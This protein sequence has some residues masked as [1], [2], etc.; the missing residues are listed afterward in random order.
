MSTRKKQHGFS[1]IELMVVI[2]VVGSL[3]G[4]AMPSLRATIDRNVVSSETIRLVRSINLARSQ[5]VNKQQVVTLERKSLMAGDWSAGWRTFTDS[6]GDGL[7]TFDI[8]TDT[9]IGDLDITTRSLTVQNLA[10]AGG[11][12]SFFPSGRLNE[13]VP[14]EIAVCD[15]ALSDR[16]DGSLIT[17]NLVGRTAVTIIPAATKAADCFP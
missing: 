13:N 11:F 15:L 7:T 1:L 9:L 3:T 17:I 4:M 8:A 12:I 5:A 14:V 10:G 16:V 6:A 2:V